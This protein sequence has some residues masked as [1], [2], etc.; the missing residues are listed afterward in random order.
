MQRTAVTDQD[1]IRDTVTVGQRAHESG[2]RIV[3]AAKIDGTWK[4]PVEE[5]TAVEIDPD[6]LV[7]AFAQTPAQAA[8]ERAERSLEKQE[9][10]VPVAI[11]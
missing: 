11:G 2:P 3:V 8:E 5:I 4:G 7:P 1:N 10:T 9:D 6:D